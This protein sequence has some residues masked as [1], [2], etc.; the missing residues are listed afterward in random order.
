MRPG[1]TVLGNLAVDRV[2]GRSPTLG[3]CPAFAP[4]A[5]QGPDVRG[6][7]VTRLSSGHSHLATDLI[8]QQTVSVSVLPARRTNAFA[9]WYHGDERVLEVAGLGER[10]T[11]GDIDEAGVDTTWVHMAPLL[12]GE[13][14]LSLIRRL[15]ARHQLC[16]DGQGL[17]R[18][19]K[20]GALRP[21]CSFDKR[22]FRHLSVLKLAHDEA[23]IIASATFSGAVARALRVPEILVTF[24]SGGCDLY[25]DGQV[26]HVPAARRVLGVHSTGAGDVFTVAYTGCRASGYSPISAAEY[27][28]E[29]VATMLE[30]RKTAEAT[31][32]ALSTPA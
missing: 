9:L 23:D 22:I 19:P 17:V 10:W 11:I 6:R 12:R 32:P 20:L 31:E 14:G 5:F 25:L 16:L 29:V 8:G 15:A 4:I 7:I 1:V 26:R 21:T 18:E 27:A 13:F 2:D 3:G 28:S 24:G 30:R